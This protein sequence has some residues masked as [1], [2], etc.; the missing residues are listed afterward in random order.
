MDIHA[1]CTTC[2]QIET[3]K[4]IT[5]IDWLRYVNGELVQNVWPQLTDAEREVIIG[6]RTEMYICSNCWDNLFA[7][8][9]KIGIY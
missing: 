8:I 6:F 5:F 3:V 7:D 9:N 4:N 2:K 1:T